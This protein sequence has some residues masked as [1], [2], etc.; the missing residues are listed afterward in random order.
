MKGVHTILEAL[1]EI[2]R[3]LPKT[4]VRLTVLGDCRDRQ[5][6]ERLEG[7]I[8]RLDLGGK[9][10]F[11]PPIP[12][13]DLFGLFQDNDIFLFPSLYEPF[14]LTLI[15]AMASGIP[16]VASDVGGNKEIVFPGSNRTFI[17]Q[18]GSPKPCQGCIKSGRQ[19]KP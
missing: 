11:L 13:S 5:Y 1:P 16:T 4:E 19:S 7:M 17:F 18:R 3:G 10:E 15:H 14:S 6:V 9:V 12:E 8:Q 2:I